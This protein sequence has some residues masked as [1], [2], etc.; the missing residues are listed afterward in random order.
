MAETLPS[1][2]SLPL[3]DKR[4]FKKT[5][6][7]TPKYL[8]IYINFFPYI[9]KTWTAIYLFKGVKIILGMFS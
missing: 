8:D 7:F 1:T 9:Y 5:N 2:S 4:I 3:S 6:V